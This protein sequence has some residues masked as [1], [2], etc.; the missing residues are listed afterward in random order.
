MRRHCSAKRDK[1]G[2]RIGSQHLMG[3]QSQ[4]FDKAAAQF[5]QEVQ[6]ASQ[7]CD[8][9]ADRPSL[10][11]AANRLIDNGLQDGGGDVFFGST[12]VHQSLYIGF[13]K[14]AATGCDRMDGLKFLG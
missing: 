12:I 3:G 8:I 1:I 11:Q 6:R 7:K 10:G 2:S 5:G 14:N 9:A 4:R 13:G